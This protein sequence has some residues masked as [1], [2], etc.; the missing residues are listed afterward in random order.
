MAKKKNRAKK[1]SKNKGFSSSLADKLKGIE[2]KED[3]PAPAPTPAPAPASIP[4]PAPPSHLTDDELFEQAL[5]ELGPKDTYRGKFVGDVHELPGADA[6]PRGGASRYARGEREADAPKDL[7]GA[8]KKEREAAKAAQA[9][10]EADLREEVMFTRFVGLMD[11][12]T[13]DSK[14]YKQK[15]R[16]AFITLEPRGFEDE[17]PEGLITPMLPTDGPGLNLVEDLDDSQ[18]G[19]LNRARL[20]GRQNDLPT[21]NL[22]GDSL[23]DAMRQLE[24][25]AHQQ[26][27]EGTKYVRVVH[28]RGVGSAAGAPV[29]KPAV[30]GF[31][32][33]K[34]FRYLRG[35]APELTPERDYGSLVLALNGDGLAAARAEKALKIKKKDERRSRKKKAGKARSDKKYAKTKE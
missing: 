26:W 3:A 31:L 28:G 10:A 7:R 33:E 19:L 2:L 25:F 23:D 21:L 18:R 1:T 20:W 32:H 30:L 4:E 34:G 24:L 15:P 35:Y 13:D 8:S 9:K 16:E 5:S 14:Y 29:L 27:K 12:V 11:Q 17:H 6:M 22:R